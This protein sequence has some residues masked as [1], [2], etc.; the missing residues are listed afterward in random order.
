MSKERPDDGL[1]DGNQRKPKTSPAA[2]DAFL[3]GA[4]RHQ[5]GD[6]LGPKATSSSSL[7]RANPKGRSGLHQF[8]FL[9]IP[10]AVPA[11]RANRCRSS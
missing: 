3:E 2:V 9:R 6:L 1:Q 8:R 10:P 7:V 4:R 11:A 5:L